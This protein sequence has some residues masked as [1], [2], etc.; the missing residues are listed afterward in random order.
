M[1]VLIIGANGTIGKL[2]K[3]TLAPRHDIIEAGK[4]SG[5][6]QVDISNE[7]SIRQLFEQV[8]NVDAIVVAAGD[9]HF[10]AMK[11]MTE[12]QF[13][14]G[15]NSKLLGQ[16]N[17]TL[18]GQHYLNAGGSITLTSGS[19][20]HH[21]TFGGTNFSTVNAAVDGFVLGAA[22]E[23]KQDRRINVVSPAVLAES[24]HVYGAAFPGGESVPGAKVALA[25]QRSVEG[26]EN[27][28]QYRVW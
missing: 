2:V 1:K 6:Y 21:P 28:Q 10:G 19:L 4:T 15:L 18:I 7:S 17:V 20:S 12:E 13:K 16:V 11:E 8:G 3:Q 5:Q 26:F 24:W 23:L 22:L 9:V 27:G 25:Y 14:L